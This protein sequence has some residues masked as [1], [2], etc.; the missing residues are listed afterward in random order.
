M[1]INWETLISS[2]LGA[3]IGSALTLLATYFSHQLDRDKAKEDEA[4]LI[5]GFLQGI[6][7][8]IETLWDNYNENVGAHVESLQQGQPFQ[9]YWA[10]TQEYF[11]IYTENAHLIGRVDDHDLRK[12]IVSAYARSKGLIDS[13]RLNNELVH[14]YEQ[15]ASIYA[16]TQAETHG[17]QA[18][19]RMQSMIM[20]AASLKESHTKV[21]ADVT[22][23]LR[24]LRKKGVLANGSET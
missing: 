4:Q 18:N 1:T 13:Y 5:F 15:A 23:L 20:Y 24:A 6:H 16:E 19:A 3:L 17:Q 7:D 10:V 22:A 2:G 8:E 11:T 9:Y 14:K 21:K 12:Q